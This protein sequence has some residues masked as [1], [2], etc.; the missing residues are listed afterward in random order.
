MISTRETSVDRL[1]GLRQSLL[2]GSRRRPREVREVVGDVALRDDR[3]ERLE[4][5]ALAANSSEQTTTQDAPSFT[6]GALPAVVV[7]SGSKTGCEGRELLERRVA[8]DALVGGHVA[9]S[10]DLVV[11]APCVLRRRGTLV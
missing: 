7:P 11:E 5:A 10:D 6:P 9:D 3:R 1:A 8:T 4:P 2:P